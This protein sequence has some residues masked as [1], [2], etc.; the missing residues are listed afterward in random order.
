MKN[1][2]VL[3]SVVSLFFA[4]DTGT[5]ATTDF[6]GVWIGDGYVFTFSSATV[7]IQERTAGSTADH[8]TYSVSGSNIFLSPQQSGSMIEGTYN[9][10]NNNETLELTLAGYNGGHKMFLSKA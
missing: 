9:F 8:F 4:C 2:L 5:T 6:E 3:I 1:L 7:S 10:S